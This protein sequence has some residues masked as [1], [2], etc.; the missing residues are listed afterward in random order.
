MA[1]R[2]YEPPRQS[3]RGMV[4]D[5]IFLM[6]LVYAAL[7]MPLVV[8]FG[9]EVAAETEE[10]AAPTW[11]SLEQNP[12][13]AAQWEKLGMGPEEA[14]EIINTRFDYTIDPLALLGTAVVVIGYFIFLMRVSDRQYREVIAE[15]FD[16]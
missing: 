4:V 15:K 7:L 8:D 6:A 3:G 9:G 10:V 14:A 13:M 16:P 11:E 1:K 5:S 2:L 12:T